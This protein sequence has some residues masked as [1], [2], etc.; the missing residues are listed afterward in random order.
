MK[1]RRTERPSGASHRVRKWLAWWL[2]FEVWSYVGYEFGLYF[3]SRKGVRLR[4]AVGLATVHSVVVTGLVVTLIYLGVKGVSKYTYVYLDWSLRLPG[5]LWWLVTVP[6]VAAAA[7]VATLPPINWILRGGAQGLIAL[8]FH[9]DAFGATCLFAT[10][11]VVEFWRNW[12]FARFVYGR[13]FEGVLGFLQARYGIEQAR[14]LTRSLQWKLR[15]A[16]AISRDSWLE[17]QTEEGE[18]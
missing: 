16:R 11:S 10:Y 8:L 1:D 7:R 14:R 6:L 13:T 5:G 9:T 17:W 18:R 15:V 12:R 4:P 2:Q 3:A